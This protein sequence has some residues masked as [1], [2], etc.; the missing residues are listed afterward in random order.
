MRA[1]RGSGPHERERHAPHLHRETAADLEQLDVPAAA[2]AIVRAGI[3]ESGQ[4]RRPQ[5]GEFFRER[6][7]DRDGFGPGVAEGQRCLPLDEGEGHRFGKPGRRERVA[8]ESIACDARI[9]RRLRG[10]QH[11]ELTGSR[12]NP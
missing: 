5:H 9:G 12:S 6:I 2:A 4:Q 1:G 7:R 11:R 10:G 8:H 3:D